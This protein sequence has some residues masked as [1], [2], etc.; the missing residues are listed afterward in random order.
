AAATLATPQF[1]AD[2]GA[3]AS[4]FALKLILFPLM[5]RAVGVFASILGT[6]CVRLK[7]GEQ[8]PMK[9]ITWGYLVS[10]VSAFAGVAAVNAWY[11]QDP[12]T[13]QVDWRFTIASGIGI[14]LAILTLMLTNY[15]T[16]PN[17]RPVSETAIA[18]K[19][20]PATLLLSGMAEG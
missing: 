6:A 12:H 15:Y 10:S 2:Y 17:S 16:H 3:G 8:D 4:A 13:G 18:S 19:T 5:I 20:G 14:V 7:P 9:P 11:L 1:L